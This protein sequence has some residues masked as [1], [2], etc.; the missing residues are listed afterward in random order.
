MENKNKSSNYLAKIISMTISIGFLIGGGI[1]YGVYDH[2]CKNFADQCND[3]QRYASFIIMCIG[4]A[5][6]AFNCL[7]FC[8]L[9]AVASCSMLVLESNS[10]PA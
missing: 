4:G 5:F 8:C 10:S 9:L 1:A 6:T 7:C 3:T 2:Q